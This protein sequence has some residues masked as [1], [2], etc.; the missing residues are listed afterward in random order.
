[1]LQKLHV[2]LQHMQRPE[3]PLP[4][5]THTSLERALGV[6][7]AL[8][9]RPDGLRL[10]ELAR[11]AG[12]HKSTASRLLAT[13][14]RYGYVAR[15][16]RS[17]RYALGLKVLTLAHRKLSD[18]AIQQECEPIV[19]DLVELSG[20]TASVAV[21][22][23][24]EIVYIYRLRGHPGARLNTPV[25]ARA[26]AHCTALGKILLAEHTPSEVLRLLGRG[27]Y[28]AFT[29]HTIVTA[30]ALLED[31]ERTAQRQYA[32]ND[33]EHR[34]GQL[35]LAVPVR[36]HTGMAVGGISLSGSAFRIRDRI[37]TLL[38][39][40]TAAADTLSATLGYVPAG[41]AP[42]TREER[43]RADVVTGPRP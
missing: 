29:E 18:M 7:E 34:P 14:D 35:C 6:L 19:R 15:E 13:L 39:Y 11:I 24:P 42:V 37:P 36:N 31:L 9:S 10:A 41:S 27:P 40:L 23:G 21:L 2:K 8:A 25:G 22:D 1:M 17:G 28:R 4:R 3:V 16:S 5:P 30:D 12:C 32:I 20:E 43:D 38:R 33:Q 26:P